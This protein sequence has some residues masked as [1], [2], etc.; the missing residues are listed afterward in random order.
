MSTPVR[1]TGVTTALLA[2][3]LHELALLASVE[4]D[5]FV[6]FRRLLDGSAPLIR[7]EVEGP[8]SD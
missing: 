2:R 7:A 3:D 1:V 4:L 8:R 5:G 6:I